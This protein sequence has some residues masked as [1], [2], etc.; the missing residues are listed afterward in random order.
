MCL[1][2]ADFERE[3]TVKKSVKQFRYVL[4]DTLIGL[5]ASSEGKRPY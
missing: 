4:I 1:V 5:S 2:A 3:I